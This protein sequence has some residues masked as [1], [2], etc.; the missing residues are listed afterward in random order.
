MEYS[1]LNPK[2]V[3]KFFKE[4]SDIPRCSGDEKAISDYLVNFAKERNL[5]VRQDEALNVVMKKKASAGYESK[6]TIALQ[7]HMDMVCVK[8][9]DSDHDF[10]KNPIKLLV[11]GNWVT[12]DKTTL[13]ADDGMGLAFILAV[14]DD[15]S[16][17][18]GPLEAIV[19]TGE[20]TAMV[21]A[22][23]LDASD[24]NAKYLINID[25]EEEASLTIGCAGGLD[26]EISFD[27]EYEEA[28]GDFIKV[29]LRGFE[30]GHSGMEI[31]K[32]RINAIQT[33]A[34]LLVDI[35][36][37]Q[38]AEINGGIKRNAIASTAYAIASVADSKS[39]IEEISKRKEDILNESKD[40]DPNG[41][42]TI[43][44]T[45][46]QGKVIRQKISQN[47]VDCIFTLPNGL[48]KKYQGE[49]ITSSNLGILED[50]EDEIRLCSMIRSQI[51]SAKFNRAAIA[52]KIVEKFGA[53]AKSERP[54]TG[55]QREETKL[56]DIA[57]DIWKEQNGSEMEIGTTHGGLECG[58]F[59]GVMPNVE[60]ISIGP[61]IKG[62]HS[63]VERVNI[64][65]VENNYKLIK[66]LLKRI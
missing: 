38:I 8:E 29:D 21:G 47:L 61:E 22:N 27:K 64:K 9:D 63:P 36:G 45:T 52:T 55:W 30:G 54:Y 62:A 16:L 11:D 2:E 60:M 37:L 34:R 23:A 46:Y 18:H 56:V 4:L 5:E 28:K 13:G 32:A 12:A 65:S 1:E 33:L 59:K 66:E 42:I 14:F 24:I 48:Y 20:E 15:D 7:A 35:D 17:E 10:S 39:A 49:I 53:R 50:R 41:Q 6:D 43:E 25:S 40:T 26:L 3:W 31:D 57:N 19:T 51:D 44:E 58:L